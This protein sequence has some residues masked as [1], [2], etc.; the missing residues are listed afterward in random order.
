MMIA[1]SIPPTAPPT[2]G[3]LEEEAERLATTVK[4]LVTH[5]EFPDE[6]RAV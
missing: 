5:A 4:F 3:A 2:A 1:A 6:S